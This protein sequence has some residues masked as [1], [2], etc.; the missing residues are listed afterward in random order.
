MLELYSFRSRCCL[1]S[2]RHFRYK[3][4]HFCLPVPATSD[5]HF[6]RCVVIM[7]INFLFNS[8][9]FPYLWTERHKYVTNELSSEGISL[10]ICKL[11]H[12]LYFSMQ[13]ITFASVQI[14]RYKR[15]IDVQFSLKTRSAIRKKLLWRVVSLLENQI[16]WG[17]FSSEPIVLVSVMNKKSCLA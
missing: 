7:L 10:A 11:S 3:F 13:H 14:K 12:S 9:F 5:F 17:K 6:N 2:R 16:V 1:E 4:S 15:L 8:N